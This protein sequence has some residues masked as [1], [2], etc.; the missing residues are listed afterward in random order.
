MVKIDVPD[1]LVERD[2]DF[3]WRLRGEII[4]W[5]KDTLVCPQ[6]VAAPS[7][8]EF[9][10]QTKS[11]YSLAT[12]IWSVAFATADDAMLFKLAWCG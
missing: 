7:R 1:T 6:F 3:N 2:A 9:K 12:V 8:F 5:C 4:E 11:K 10:S